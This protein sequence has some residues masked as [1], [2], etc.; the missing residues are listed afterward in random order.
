MNPIVH[1]I[2]L[3]APGGNLDSIK[4]AIAGGA[5]AVYCGLSRFNARNRARNIEV[6]DLPRIVRLAHSKNCKLFITLNIIIVENEIPALITLLN[7]LVNIRIDGVIVQD[8]GLFY[9]L[10]HFYKSIPIHAST[11]LTTHNAG[12]IAFLSRLTATRVNLSRE[13]SIPEIKEL[14]TIAH[15]NSLLTEVFVHGSNCLSFSGLCYFSSVHGGNSGNR[16]RC[17]QPCRHQY[18]KTV[19][20]NDF[21]L[22]LKDNSA[23]ADLGELAAAGVDSV[24]IEGRIKKFHYVYTVVKAFRKQLQ[25][26]Y[27][28]EVL[29]AEDSSLRKVFNRD[30]TDSFLQG[31]IGQDMF[32]DNPRD[33]SALYRSKMYGGPSCEN[34]ERAK[35]ELY[36]EKTAIINKVEQEIEKLSIGKVPL[37]IYVSGKVGTPLTLAVET[38]DETFAVASKANLAAIHTTSASTECVGSEMLLLRLKS[39]D[40][41]EYYIEKMVQENLQNNLFLAFKEITAL[42]KKIVF[43]LNGSKEGIAPLDVPRLTVPQKLNPMP[44]LS[45]LIASTEDAYLGNETTSDIYFQLPDGLAGKYDELLTFFKK[46]KNLI[47]WFSTVIIG[48]DFHAAEGFLQELKPA[49][50]VVNN[51]GIAWAAFKQGIPWIAGPYLNSVNSFSLLCMKEHFNCSGA[52]ISNELNKKQI[53]PIKKPDDFEFYYSIYHPIPL[54]TSRQ[55]LLHQV[56]GCE[57]NRIDSS[58]VQQCAKSSTITNLKNDTFFLTKT[59]GNYHRLYNE[60]N[61][62][63]TDIVADFENF[64]SGFFID[65]KDVQTGTAIHVTKSKLIHLFQDLLAGKSRAAEKIKQNIQPTTCCQYQKGI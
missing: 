46:N 9:L 14:A 1:K 6:D 60:S 28:E 8:L 51:T 61:Y 25:H 26:L 22:N 48:A 49:K 57:K 41:T 32:I 62:L 3:L 24:K 43:I 19:A 44:S 52:F 18:E 39:I 59:K 5:D 21:P 65:L 47:P 53:K 45:I 29:P 56:T 38:P 15:E 50:I 58:C 7:K 23:F 16:G 30:F 27:Q 55:C 40:D 10:N 11:Q 37:Q 17:S 64:F 4:A 20:G 31:V 13:L 35:K 12:Q 2:E 42:K 34:L 33:Y 63:N 54:M 36:D